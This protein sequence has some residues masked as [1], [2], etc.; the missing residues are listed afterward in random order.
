MRRQLL[1]HLIRRKALP[2]S[3]PDITGD[4]LPDPACRDQLLKVPAGVGKHLRPKFT[5]I[6]KKA[7]PIE[8]VQPH[9]VQHK[10]VDG[11]IGE[12][13]E[14]LLRN[15][16]PQLI[17]VKQI[18]QQP[19]GIVPADGAEDHV[20]LR[21]AKSL[22]KVLRPLLR[23]LSDVIDTLQRV[24]HELDLQPV[25]PQPAEPDLYFKLD[26]FLS[27]DTAGETDDPDRLYHAPPP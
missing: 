18:R 8:G 15:G 5:D 14:N 21:I 23:M 27:D 3:I 16:L 9:L 2:L 17:M 1:T 12:S 22:Q 19:E 26:K 7:L 25:F 20:D 4:D 10:V 13:K 11:G 6:R 24:G